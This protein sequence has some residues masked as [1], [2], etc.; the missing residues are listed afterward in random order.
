MTTVARIGYSTRDHGAINLELHEV[1]HAVDRFVYKNIS[2]H[3]EFL[4]IYRE[5]SEF[6]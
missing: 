4:D 2:R 1:G 5:E 6:F 3:S